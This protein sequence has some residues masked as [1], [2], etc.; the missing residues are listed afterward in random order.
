MSVVCGGNFSGY[1]EIETPNYPDLYPKLVDCYWY[2]DTESVDQRISLVFQN[3]S[4]ANVYDWVSVRNFKDRNLMLSLK[5]FFIIIGKVYEG[6]DASNGETLLFRYSGNHAPWPVET[7]KT[8]KMLVHFHSE[9]LTT[10]FSFGF[11]AYFS[12][13]LVI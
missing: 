13:D 5:I 3:F 11:S 4:I 7:N 8:S 10:I 6:W 12:T 1:G 9:N 2:L